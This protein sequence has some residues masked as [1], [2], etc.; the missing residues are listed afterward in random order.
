MR[1]LLILVVCTLPACSQV[2]SGTT[3]RASV[4]RQTSELFREGTT[5]WNV[6]AEMRFD[7]RR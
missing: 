5:A 1:I 7:V 2:L 4:G 6:G 3:Y